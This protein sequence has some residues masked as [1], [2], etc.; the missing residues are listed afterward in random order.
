MFSENV[1]AYKNSTQPGEEITRKTNSFFSENYFNNP[2]TEKKFSPPFVPGEIYFFRYQTDSKISKDRP[3]INRLPL[4]L[5]TDVIET[6]KSG[7]VIKGIDMIVVP[8]KNRIDI[9]EKFYDK[10]G[11]QIKANDASYEKGS[12]KIPVRFSSILLDSLFSGTGYK[13]AIFGFKYRFVRNPGVISSSDWAKIPYLSANLIEG[14]PL[15][16]IY[17]EYQTKLNF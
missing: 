8:P 10:F 16:G 12:S 15:Q 3:F 1:L 7:T 17:S 13:K 11:Q 9:L 14:M 6:E 5:C 4:L 2:N